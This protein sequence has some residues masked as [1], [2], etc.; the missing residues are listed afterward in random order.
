MSLW[1]HLPIEA[2]RGKAASAPGGALV[3]QPERAL[4]A[5]CGM[6]ILT[7]KRVWRGPGVWLHWNCSGKLRR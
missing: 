7:L 1:D 4:C 3:S 5:Y 6:P 2:L